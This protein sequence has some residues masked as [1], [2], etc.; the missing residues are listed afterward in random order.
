M[1]F[2]ELIIKIVAAVF[3]IGAILLV[4]YF[5][6]KKALQ[7]A[8]RMNEE[9]MKLEKDQEKIKKSNDEKVRGK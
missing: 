2:E 1:L 8:K 9:F 6:N 3:S 7:K 4:I 5:I